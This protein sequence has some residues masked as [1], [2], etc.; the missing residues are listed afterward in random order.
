MNLVP[1]QNQNLEHILESYSSFPEQFQKDVDLTE[2]IFRTRGPA[3]HHKKSYTGSRNHCFL[4]FIERR[5]DQQE[6]FSVFSHL[7]CRSAPRSA[8]I[9][10]EMLLSCLLARCFF[11]T[12]KTSRATWA[13]MMAANM[14]GHP[15]QKRS[16]K[17]SRYW[18][19]TK[20]GSG[21]SLRFNNP[22]IKFL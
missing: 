15:F 1:F 14:I 11:I 16:E 5:H 20:V 17:E 3:K 2:H 8:C 21:W 12:S 19:Q 22:P 9:S 7:P 18:V 4:Q 6:L 10:K 13:P